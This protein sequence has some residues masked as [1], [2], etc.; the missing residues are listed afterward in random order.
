MCAA[1]V[2]C[3]GSMQAEC[4]QCACSV[5]STPFHMCQDP[6]FYPTR[7]RYFLGHGSIP[8]RIEI[9]GSVSV[10]HSLTSRRCQNGT[11]EYLEDLRIPIVGL[12]EGSACS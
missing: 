4:M 7:G 2:Q 12:C 6:H 3:V 10:N 9:L 5:H 8:G 11:S 1:L